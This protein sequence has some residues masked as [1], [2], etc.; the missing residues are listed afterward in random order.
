MSSGKTHAAAAKVMMIPIA[1]ASAYLF[2]QGYAEASVGV[3]AGGIAAI[4]V[5]PDADVDGVSEEELRWFRINPILGHMWHLFWYAYGKLF[6]H[7]GI[8]HVP[9]VGTATRIL[10]IAVLITL[11]Q[12]LFVIVFGPTNFTGADL[13]ISL[14]YNNFKFFCRGVFISWSFQDFIHIIF[15]ICSTWL[16]RRRLLW[17]ANL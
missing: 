13:Y 14:I 11:L 4:F 1:A 6:K 10:Y 2:S 9:F 3:I 5:T 12:L 15:D 7:R 16:K 17:Y 8:S